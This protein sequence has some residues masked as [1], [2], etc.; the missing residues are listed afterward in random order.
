MHRSFR[1]RSKVDIVTLIL[2][3]LGLAVIVAALIAAG[4]LPPHHDD[5]SGKIE[6]QAEGARVAREFTVAGALSNIP[7]D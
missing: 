1:E 4:V 6:A 7:D 3:L 2:G 5:P